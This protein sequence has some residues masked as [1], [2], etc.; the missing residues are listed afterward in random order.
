ML[1]RV[2]AL[3]PL[4]PNQRYTIHE[5]CCY[6]RHSRARLYQKVARGELRLIKDGRRSY[7][8]GADLIA[9]GQ[10]R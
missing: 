7:I 9:A 8:A 6:L 10:R 1:S 2:R 5:G 4:D 3:P